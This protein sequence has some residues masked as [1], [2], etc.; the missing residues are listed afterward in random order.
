MINWRCFV[1]ILLFMTTFSAPHQAVSDSWKKAKNDVADT[2][3]NRIGNTF[4]CGCLYESHDDRDG[5]ATILD[6]N[7]CYNWRS[8]NYRDAACE[9]N[10]EHIVPVNLTPVSYR[11]CWVK[12]ETFDDKCK[13]KRGRECCE[14]Y[15]EK[16]KEIIFDPHNLVPAVG[17]INQLRRDYRYS[18]LDDSTTFGKCSAGYEEGKFEPPD[19][20]KGD[21]ARIWFYMR[22]SHDVEISPQE[23]EMFQKW[24]Q[25]D[26]VSP[27]EQERERRIFA[28][29]KRE[30][31][32]VHG[33]EAD[34]AGACPWEPKE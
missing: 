30:N 23:A 20:K 17:Q 12:P 32:H 22:D 26:P 25:S 19:C 5:S 28:L 14:R 10:W 1:A 27:W 4:Y 9:L 24:S 2:V 8:H 29:S 13:G 34:V 6:F 11:D 3:Y 7:D 33:K 18:D 31:R 15:D 16:A 21:V